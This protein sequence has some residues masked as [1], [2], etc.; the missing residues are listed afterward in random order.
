MRGGLYVYICF[1]FIFDNLCCGPA[2]LG[3]KRTLETCSDPVVYKRH[4]SCEKN[5]NPKWLYGRRINFMSLRG[6][7]RGEIVSKQSVGVVRRKIII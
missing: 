3:I 4:C 5:K 2:H 7:G 1:V 6:T